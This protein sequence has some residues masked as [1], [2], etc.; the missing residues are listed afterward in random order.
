MS[1][2]TNNRPPSPSFRDETQRENEGRLN[3][4][5]NEMASIKVIMER[6][7]E[8]NSV[9]VRQVDTASTKSSFCAQASHIALIGRVTFCEALVGEQHTAMYF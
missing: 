6:L 2:R 5:Q 4:L 8:Q 9:K 1:T 7:L 3:K